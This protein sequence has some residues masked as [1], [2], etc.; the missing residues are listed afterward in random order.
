[1]NYQMKVAI[2]GD[3]SGYTSKPLRDFIRESNKGSAVGFLPTME[4][5]VAWLAGR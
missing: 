4:E 3:Y 2:W 5:A 1:M